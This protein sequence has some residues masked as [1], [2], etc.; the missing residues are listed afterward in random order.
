MHSD[1]SKNRFHELPVLIYSCE[2][3]VKLNCY[4]NTIRTIPEGIR[5]LQN[6]QHVNLRQ[7]QIVSKMCEVISLFFSRNF[8]SLFPTELCQLQKLRSLAIS[9]NR[10]EKIPEEIGRLKELHSLVSEI[11]KHQMFIQ[12]TLYIYYPT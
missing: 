9:N 4:H 6:L 12:Y 10:I 8:L 11:I 2:A 5:R 3:L 7:V 1:I